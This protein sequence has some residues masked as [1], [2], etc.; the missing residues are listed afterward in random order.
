MNKM[1][2]VAALCVAVDMAVVFAGC[3]GMPRL[4]DND[5]AGCVYIE[6]NSSCALNSA[7]RKNFLCRVGQGNGTN[8]IEECT[9][10]HLHASED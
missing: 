10:E 4:I 8:C 2:R 9:C 7:C 5:S 6:T 3:S 1:L